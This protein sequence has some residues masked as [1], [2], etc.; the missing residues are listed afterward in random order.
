M[1]ASSINRASYPESLID[2][3]IDS[4]RA[5]S[6][7]ASLIAS[8]RS[9][10]NCL[11]LSSTIVPPEVYSTRYH[12]CYVTACRHVKLRLLNRNSGR[13]RNMQWWTGCLWLK[14]DSDG[15]R[16]YSCTRT[17]GLRPT[18]I[19]IPHPASLHKSALISRAFG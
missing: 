13:E 18:A 3:K 15:V 9:F 5:E 17:S 14:P 11:T 19:T 7:T 16:A 8:P 1:M 12:R 4:T 6:E 2:C 10:S